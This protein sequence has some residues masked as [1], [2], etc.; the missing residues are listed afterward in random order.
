MGLMLNG[1]FV[2]IGFIVGLYALI[3]KYR[4]EVDNAFSKIREV[5]DK[6]EKHAKDMN[7][8]V[9]KDPNAAE[10]NKHAGLL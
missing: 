6:Q 7:L 4:R 5:E 8:H 10:A 3:F 1:L 9:L 2:V